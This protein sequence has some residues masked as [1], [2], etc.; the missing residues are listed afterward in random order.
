MICKRKQYVKRKSVN[1]LFKFTVLD[2]KAKTTHIF[3]QHI[4]CSAL[5]QVN[6]SRIVLLSR[7]DLNLQIFP[8]VVCRLIIR[9]IISQAAIALF[10]TNFGPK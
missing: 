8:T 4:K 2:F 5:E 9:I 1:G 3:R 7:Q 6:A 10:K